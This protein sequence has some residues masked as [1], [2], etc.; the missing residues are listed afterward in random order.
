MPVLN[1]AQLEH[2]PFLSYLSKLGDYRTQLNQHFKKEIL[3]GHY[4]GSE[5]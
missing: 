1:L 4:Y 5:C 2:E 3:L